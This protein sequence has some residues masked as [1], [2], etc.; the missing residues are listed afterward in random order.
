M[1]L[2]NTYINN[3]YDPKS[4]SNYPQAICDL[5]TF[6]CTATLK[7]I[8]SGSCATSTLH[9]WRTLLPTQSYDLT[10]TLAKEEPLWIEVKRVMGSASPLEYERVINILNSM[11]PDIQAHAERLL[12]EE[13]ALEEHE[14]EWIKAVTEMQQNE[15]REQYGP[16]IRLARTPA[17]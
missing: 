2:P 9:N 1:A 15:L 7:H 3:M 10:Q 11:H 13:L 17:R 5:K 16:K 14:W 4:N 6:I 12:N 8:T